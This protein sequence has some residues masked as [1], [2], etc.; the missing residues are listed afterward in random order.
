MKITIFGLPGAGKST[1]GKALADKLGYVYMSSGNIFR[2]M[3]NNHNMSIYE[4]DEYAR[5]NPKFDIELDKHV[6]K[7]GVE[8]DNFVFE[9]RLAW[10]FI[11]D[12]F[13]IKLL[14]EEDVA[15]K[16]I[17]ERE[18]ISFDEAKS[19]TVKR[20]DTISNRY[21]NIYPNIKYPP[22]DLVFDLI[23]DNTYISVDKQL[24]EIIEKLNL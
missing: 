17:S 2:E 4:F 12:S 1:V 21:K 24:S 8:N 19:K 23:I 18:N 9:S 22:E 10:H 20:S 11:P 15:F 14:C 6:E 5:D 3:A 7:F 16:R 13:K